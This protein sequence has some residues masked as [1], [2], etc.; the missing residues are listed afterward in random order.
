MARRVALASIGLSSVLLLIFC[1][2]GGSKGPGSGLTW[3]ELGFAVV[4]AAF[5]VALMLLGVARPGGRAAAAG[6]ILLL[7]ILLEAGMAGM[8]FFRG[9]VATG[10]WALGLPLAA[11]IQIYGI[12]IAPLALV[13]LGY[14]LTFGELEVSERDLERLRRAG[15]GSSPGSMG[16][17]E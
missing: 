9:Q 17:G 5:P 8:L 15:S 12:L 11:S 4:A 13:A 1:V 14:A 6:P 3:S 10:P 7:L 16:R 2:V